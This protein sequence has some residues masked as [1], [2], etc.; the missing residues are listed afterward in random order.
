MTGAQMD[1]APAPKAGSDEASKVWVSQH[2]NMVQ[3]GDEALNEEEEFDEE[4]MVSAVS[5]GKGHGNHVPPSFY[6]RD[7]FK[8]LETEG[9][10]KIP[11]Q[12]GF[13]LGYHTVTKQ[14]HARWSGDGVP[15]N[16]A[17]TCGMLRSELKA[18]CMAL[19]QLWDWYLAVN[20]D[21]A[22]EEHL[23]RLSA[24]MDKIAF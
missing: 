3:L 7:E 16:Y 18:L 23:K 6:E 11:D 19:C 1:P 21:S 4:M 15:K 24:Y 8:T 2:K 14:W 10:A 22:G 13:M 20:E 9:L 12:Q 5:K 17:P